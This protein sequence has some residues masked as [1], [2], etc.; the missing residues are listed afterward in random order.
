M[1][2]V[3]ALKS[4][5]ALMMRMPADDTAWVAKYEAATEWLKTKE[6]VAKAG[7][8]AQEV[9]RVGDAAQEPEPVKAAPG[10]ARLDVP[11]IG[12]LEPGS[13][14]RTLETVEAGKAE[15][16]IRDARRADVEKIK[17]M[18]EAPPDVGKEEVQPKLQPER[19]E[20]RPQP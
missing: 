14:T 10:C 7:A 13:T 8:S 12:G 6:A 3:K 16:S 17:E 2:P 19:A 15:T 4:G 11:G 20:P 1:T 18:V 5:A 9:A